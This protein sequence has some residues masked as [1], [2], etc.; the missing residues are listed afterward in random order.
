ML[1]LMLLQPK[2]AKTLQQQPHT[3]RQS[4]KQNQSKT[5]KPTQQEPQTK[6]KHLWQLAQPESKRQTQPNTKRN[7]NWNLRSCCGTQNPFTT[8]SAKQKTEPETANPHAKRK[9]ATAILKYRHT[10]GLCCR[11]KVYRCP[12][13]KKVKVTVFAQSADV[14]QAGANTNQK[15]SKPS[16]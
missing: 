4:N 1:L 13:R 7:P 9:A 10:V 3:K 12:N 5:T 6:H 15:K 16:S 8:T 11:I 2:S 14:P